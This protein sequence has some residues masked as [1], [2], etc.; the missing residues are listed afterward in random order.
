MTDKEKIRAEIERLYNQSLVDENRQADRGLERAANVSYGKSIV[1]KELLLFIASLPEEPVSDDLE[2]VVEEIV[3]PTV[4][5]AYGVKEIANRL[6]N[7]ICGTSVSEDLKRAA[8]NY[9]ENINN[10]CGSIGKQVKNAFK[11][12]AQ[13][14]FNQLEKNRLTACDRASKEEI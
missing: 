1:C 6:H 9:S 14:Q 4:L 8:T 10:I 13:W 2:K 7:T 11:A 3:D 5:N 12:G